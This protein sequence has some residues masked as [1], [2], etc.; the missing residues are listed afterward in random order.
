MGDGGGVTNLLGV[1]LGWGSS[2]T[3]PYLGARTVYVTLALARSQVG[4]CFTHPIQSPRSIPS[5][6]A[7][8]WPVR[9][10]PIT[11]TATAHQLLS[12]AVLLGSVR[13]PARPSARPS[14]PPVRPGPS[15]HHPPSTI[16]PRGKEDDSSHSSLAVASGS[17]VC[18]R[19]KSA[20]PSPCGKELEV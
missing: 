2:R 6:C 18:R 14:A 4:G 9:H 7:P 8:G 11:A 5:Y 13:P 16:H 19:R 15:V 1:E 12:S 10:Q 17:A 3:V 20:G